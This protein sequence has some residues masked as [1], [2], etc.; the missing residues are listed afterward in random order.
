MLEGRND[1]AVLWDIR[2]EPRLRGKGIGKT[3]FEMAEV[4]A[5]ERHCRTLK[6]E[7]QDVNPSACFF[8]LGRGCQLKAVMPGVYKFF[9]DEIQL[10]WYKSLG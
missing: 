4:W 9:P 3:L 8:Y 5:Q 6:V 7:T 1:L 10:L 2:V